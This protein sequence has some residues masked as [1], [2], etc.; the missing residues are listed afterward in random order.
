[1]NHIQGS[2]TW[3]KSRT[4]NI[5]QIRLKNKEKCAILGTAL[6]VQI[7]AIFTSVLHMAEISQLMLIIN[8]LGI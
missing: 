8:V 6:D 7:N 2:V 4:E 5:Q 1:M 3:W